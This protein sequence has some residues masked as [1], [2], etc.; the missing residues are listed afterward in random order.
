[1]FFNRFFGNCSVI[2][3]FSIISWFVIL[4]VGMTFSGSCGGVV[5]ALGRRASSEV[6][7]NRERASS[8]WVLGGL[9]RVIFVVIVIVVIFVI[10]IYVI[11]CVVRIILSIRL[12]SIRQA[13]I[14]K[15]SSMWAFSRGASVPSTSGWASG[16][17]ASR[18][19]VISVVFV[20]VCVLSIG[21]V[22]S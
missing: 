18:D 19:T 2:A 6:A 14:G 5:G 1:M 22:S 9:F 11:S 12:A 3:H 21:L 16:G 8:R 20:F 13:S 17:S 4:S 10:G 7:S 15:E